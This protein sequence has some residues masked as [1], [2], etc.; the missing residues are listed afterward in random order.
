MASH[1]PE[2]VL[3]PSSDYCES[4]VI[5]KDRDNKE[6]RISYEKEGVTPF[7]PDAPKDV[8]IQNDARTRRTWPWKWI[9]GILVVSICMLA[10]GIGIGYAVGENNNSKSDSLR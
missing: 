9:I 8:E 2:V 4:S 1:A 6:I 5:E 10:I 3:S 7:V